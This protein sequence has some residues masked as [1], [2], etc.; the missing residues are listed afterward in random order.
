MNENKKAYEIDAARVLGIF[1]KH[2]W[3]IAIATLVGA[4][5]FFIHTN[6]FVTP[7]YK[8]ESVLI[9]SDTEKDNTSYQDI[10]AGQYQ[11]YDYPYILD[12]GITY[13]KVADYLNKNNPG[14]SYSASSIKA[15]T[16]GTSV[17]NSRIFVISVS[18]RDPEEAAKVANAIAAVFPDQVSELIPGSKIGIV[19]NAV[20]PT[21][22]SSPNLTVNIV[23]GA[24]IGLA[25]GLGVTALLGFT[26]DSVESE[27]WLLET[28]KDEIPLLAVIPDSSSRGYKYDKYKYK[29][30]SYTYRSSG[31]Q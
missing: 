19:D 14:S 27:K 26:N 8:A 1:A 4:I 7:I 5:L 13:G 30:K 25:L 18:S 6:F 23:L 28:F 31:K 17:E 29:Y 3:I 21:A 20:V 2:W 11:S 10:V 12:S 9:I 16:V 24:I 15:M 22:P